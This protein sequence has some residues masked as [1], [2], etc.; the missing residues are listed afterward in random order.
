MATGLLCDDYSSQDGRSTSLQ[1]ENNPS[2]ID[3][4]LICID[5]VY[6]GGQ[7]GSIRPTDNPYLFF[8]S[9]FFPVLTSIKR[10]LLLYHIVLVKR[11]GVRISPTRYCMRGRGRG[12][13]NWFDDA[14]ANLV[15]QSNWLFLSFHSVAEF[16]WYIHQEAEACFDDHLP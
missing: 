8:Y 1:A 3:K 14:D 10:R 13:R 15:D 4:S 9:H 6:F 16:Q 2:L 7:W 11:I 5:L 12:N